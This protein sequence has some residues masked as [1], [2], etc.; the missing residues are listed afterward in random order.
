[1]Q[2]VAAGGGIEGREAGARLHRVGHQTL[3]VVDDLGDKARA[4]ERR[5]D[6]GFV[7]VLMGIGQVGGEFC[8]HHRRARGERVFEADHR[9][10]LLV[11]DLDQLGRILR[12]GL[13][14]GDDERDGLA[15]IG[16]AVLRQHRIVRL[17]HAFA[18]L[19]LQ[20][21]AADD[22][23][24]AGAF[25]IGMGQHGAHAGHGQRGRGVDADDAGGGVR[26]AQHRGVE[27][28]WKVPVAG[29]AALPGDQAQVFST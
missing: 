7:A 9:G 25:G 18:V 22:R 10:R 24:E 16:H 14:V 29:I 3:A 19:V 11:L 12:G 26:R 27:L 21:D 2:G 8:V 23:L 15:H 28:P 17:L 1:M 20:G 13:G 6:R 5:S 4:R